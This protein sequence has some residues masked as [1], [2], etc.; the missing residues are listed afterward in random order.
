MGIINQCKIIKAGSTELKQIVSPPTNSDLIW[1]MVFLILGSSANLSKIFWH[2]NE[3]KKGNEK[4]K[5]YQNSAKHLRTLL[6][7]DDDCYLSSR[8]LRNDFEHFDERLHEWAENSPTKN[9]IDGNI[10]PEGFID[11]KSTS[12]YD[13]MRHFDQYK[14]IVTFRSNRF[15]INPIVRETETILKNAEVKLKERRFRH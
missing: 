8:D 14:F 9:I 15:E 7:I 1:G 11:I 5:K 12:S 13:I 2:S 10:G 4:Y 6:M 3:N